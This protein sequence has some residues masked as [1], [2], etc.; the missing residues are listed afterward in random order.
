MIVKIEKMGINGEG[1]AF[2]NRQPIFIEGAIEGETCDIKIIE[3]N[4]RFCRGVIVK[5]ITKSKD[6]IQKPCKYASNCGA[7]SLMHIQYEKQLEIKSA[8]LRESLIKYA[9]LDPRRIERI[10][11]NEQPFHYRNSFK[12]PF[13]MDKGKLVCGLYKPNSNYFVPVD[14]CM[15]HEQGLER[16]RKQLLAIFNQFQLK[17]Y[18]HKKKTGLRTL[19]LRGF[20][21][22]YQCCIVSG[23]KE[24]PKEC[25]DQCMQIE[26]ITSLWQSYHTVKKTVDLFG[27]TMIHLGGEKQ[28]H[29]QLH[30]LDLTLSPRSFFQLNTVQ[31]EKL[32]A[33]AAQMVADQNE[34]V[35]E[36]YSGIGAISL[37]IKDKA[38]EIIGIESIQDA[39]SNANMNA[40]RNHIENV[41]F[42]CGDAAEKLTQIAKKRKID[43]LIVDPPRTGLDDEM[44]RCIIK[45][46]IKNIIYISCN[47]STLGKNLAVLQNN[48]QVLRVVPIDMFSNAATVETIVQLTLKH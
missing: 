13:S 12:L 31:A 16:I 42:Q 15:I 10:I 8:V 14:Y 45:S 34:L 27:K 4:A 36:A 35:V 9:H 29:L 32:Y 40:K 38:K 46:K 26:G 33:M 47:T 19:I 39:V 28:L 25:I 43:T 17:S 37:Y 2:Q 22:Q 1:I 24:L 23:E 3:K 20:H 44:L 30:N 5:V 41:H 11:K 7:C 21:D 6:R 48:Y 18:D